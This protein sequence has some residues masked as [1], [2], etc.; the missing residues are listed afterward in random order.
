MGV[1]RQYSAARMIIYADRSQ[2]IG[3]IR[4]NS[5]KL[6]LGKCFLHTITPFAIRIAKKSKKVNENDAFR[7]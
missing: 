4:I 5:F 2:R 3:I 6:S 1:V 7:H